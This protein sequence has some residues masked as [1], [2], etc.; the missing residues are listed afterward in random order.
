MGIVFRQS[1]K[2]TI[3]AFVGAAMGGVFI[4]LRIKGLDTRE[5]G[6]SADIINKGSLMTLFL[7]LG[8]A[9]T[10][11]TYIHRYEKEMMT[12]KAC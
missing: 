8:M 6:Y 3:I 7:G 12:V 5:Q 2:S 4:W 1:I 10:L 9:P 11:L